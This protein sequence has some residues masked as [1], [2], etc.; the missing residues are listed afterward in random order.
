MKKIAFRRAGQVLLLRT[1]RLTD[2]DFCVR[3]CAETMEWHALVAHRL[4][5]LVAFLAAMRRRRSDLGTRRYS[6]LLA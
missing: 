5:R 2:D 6:S 4:G 1:G 3:T